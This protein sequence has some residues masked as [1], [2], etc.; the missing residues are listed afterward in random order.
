MLKFRYNGGPSH[1][2]LG[3]VTTKAGRWIEIVTINLDKAAVF[4]CDADGCACEIASALRTT[5]QS[6]RL[7][8]YQATVMIAHA[9]DGKGCA[10][11]D[12]TAEGQ[13]SLSLSKSPFDRQWHQ[14]I[15]FGPALGLGP[16][17]AWRIKT[18]RLSIPLCRSADITRAKRRA[19]LVS[20]QT[21]AL[22]ICLLTPKWGALIAFQN[23][24]HRCWPFPNIRCSAYSPM[25]A[26]RYSAP[27]DI[28]ISQN[29]T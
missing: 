26:S 1:A 17:E 5:T 25:L 11:S 6:K 16:N 4:D 12:R 14:T 27:L 21:Q 18:V 9:A 7:R 28:K 20:D 13:P 24:L 29:R 10:A 8:S 15:Y 19:Q 23:R 3:V 22:G 2:M